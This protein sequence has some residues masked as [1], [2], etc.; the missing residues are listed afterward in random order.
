MITHKTLTMNQKTNLRVFAFAFLAVYQIFFYGCSEEEKPD[1][2][3]RTGTVADG[4][5]NVYKTVFLGGQEWMAENLRVTTYNNGDNIPGALFANEWTDAGSGAWTVYP[6][7]DVEG[8]A[9]AGE[10]TEAYGIL[11]NWYA[12][13]DPRGLCPQGWHVPHDEEWGQLVA[14]LVGQGF[15]NEWDNPD[16]AANALKSCRQVNSP[17]GDGCNTTLHPRWTPDEMYN[18]IHGFDEYEFS[19]LPGGGCS[20]IGEFSLIGESSG[21]WT[22]TE[23]L[24]T[25]AWVRQINNYSAAVNRFSNFKEAGHHVR[26]VREVD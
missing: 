5:G 1:P 3:P 16:G 6:H 12:V 13:T 17:L 24:E 9:S 11:Y 18:H 15:P 14:Y 4:D 25:G 20:H 2:K 22:T 23:F 26:C 7:D 19:A 10:M 8:I 21:F